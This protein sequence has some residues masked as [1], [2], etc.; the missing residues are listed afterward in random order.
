M[1]PK[2]GDFEAV[3]AVTDPVKWLPDQSVTCSLSLLML[4][5]QLSI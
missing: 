4:N 1:I 5:H 2:T 3:T